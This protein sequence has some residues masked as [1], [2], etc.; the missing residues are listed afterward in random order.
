MARRTSGNNINMTMT[1]IDRITTPLKKISKELNSTNSALGTTGKTFLQF[2]EAQER[3]AKIQQSTT[4]QRYQAMALNNLKKHNNAM[5]LEATRHANRMQ[6]IYARRLYAPTPSV[7]SSV[8]L[9]SNLY[10]IEKI[11][12]AVQKI[13]QAVNSIMEF[14]DEIISQK[15]RLNLYNT[16]GQ[17]TQDMYNL[18]AGTAL[19]S[20]SDLSATAQLTNRLL[21]TGIFTGE[22]AI[23]QATYI[24]GLIN[25]SLIAG[26]GTRQEISSTLLQLSQGLAQGQLQGQELKAIRQYAPYLGNI[27]IE[28]LNKQ[29][30]FDKELVYGDLKELGADGELTTER[31]IKAF[32]LMADKINSD[33]E[34]MPKT[35][36]Q[37]MENLSTLSGIFISNLTEMDTG[38]KNVNDSLWTFL[39]YLQSDEAITFWENLTIAAN[40]FF[41]LVSYGVDTLTTGLKFV[42]ENLDAI[43]VV[44]GIFAVVAVIAFIALNWQ[45]LLFI[46]ILYIVIKVLSQLGVDGVK[47]FATIISLLYYFILNTIT[48][49][50]IISTVLAGAFH[51]LLGVASTVI[52]DIL[53]LI[54]LL[55]SAMED[56]LAL[57]G[58]HV[59][60]SSKLQTA[61]DW[62]RN[63][64]DKSFANSKEAVESIGTY[65]YDLGIGNALKAQGVY[66]GI[67]D[68]ANQFNPDSFKG[69]FDIEK[70]K[71]MLGID[72]NDYIPSITNGA[73]DTNVVGG[74]LDDVSISEEDIQLLKDISARDFL[75]NVSTVTPVMNNS[76]GDIKETAD[77]NRI[78]E[79]LDRM[80]DE[81]LATSV[82]YG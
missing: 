18:V 1:L 72:P 62:A 80:V 68:A 27:L 23:P 34:T 78:L 81:E 45:V 30:I 57:F 26:G 76:F 3:A 21:A 56:V 8:D 13:A 7:S 55:A 22:N 54:Q 29:G 15:A 40:I 25:K 33:F 59:D 42:A 20:R 46:S 24:T 65:L 60:I 16:S 71:E 2:A 67:V 17:S 4:Q 50:N 63:L 64:S 36:G 35:W 5:E 77:I 52:Y 14:S 74:K 53:S 79:E 9:A 32:E 28:G 6:E 49:A 51:F 70:L 37:G 66:T 61:I 82:I 58:K 19:E 31:I 47:V 44:L 69:L 38:I 75:I 12:Q 11:A 39:D 43:L 73:V 48:V 10:I 41:V